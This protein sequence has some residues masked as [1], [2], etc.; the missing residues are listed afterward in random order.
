[1]LRVYSGKIP[2]PILL[3][4][5]SCMLPKTSTSNTAAPGSLES[6]TLVFHHQHTETSDFIV[7][8]SPN[9][10]HICRVPSG[11]PVFSSSTFILIEPPVNA[12]TG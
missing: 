2:L 7:V 8:Q 6:T 9:K 12:A 4:A 11:D 1:M 10:T 3:I 5:V